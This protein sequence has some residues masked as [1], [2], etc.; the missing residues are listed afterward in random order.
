[1]TKK[2]SMNKLNVILPSNM[3]KGG[4]VVGIDSCLPLKGNDHDT[5]LELVQICR[6]NCKD[7]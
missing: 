7:L 3:I 4:A 5:K 2:N 1:M 6:M